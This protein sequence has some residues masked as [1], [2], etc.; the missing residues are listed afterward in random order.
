MR[1]VFQS[2]LWVGAASFVT[3]SCSRIQEEPAVVADP[4]EQGGTADFYM[5][6]KAGDPATKTVIDDQGDSYE[7]CSHGHLRFVPFR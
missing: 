4:V 5:Q 7:S 3:L 6:V 2:L 1:K